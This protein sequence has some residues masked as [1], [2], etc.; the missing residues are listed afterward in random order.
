MQHALPRPPRSPALLVRCRLPRALATLPAQSH[1]QLAA[2]AS[3]PALP[4]SSGPTVSPLSPAAPVQAG[5]IITGTV[6]DINGG[7]VPGAQVTLVEIGK[8]GERVAT[9]D[10]AGVFT[11]DHLP[12]GSY[13]VTITAPGLETFVSSAIVLRPDTRHELPRIALPIATAN[14]SVQVSV[15]QEQLADEQVKAAERQRVFGVF[16]NFY[17]S[18]IWDAAPLKAR[19]KFHLGLRSATDPI[20]FITTG[21]I[22]GSE[23]ANNTFS[24]YGQGTQGYAKRYGAAYADGFIGRIFGSAVFPSVFRQDPRYFYMGPAASTRTRAFHAMRSA[25][26][27]R[28]DN[29]HWQPN[30]SYILGHIVAGAA[31]N[32][33]HPASDR[34][35]ALTF[36][37]ALVGTAGHMGANL[38]RE[39]LLRGLTSHVPDFEQGKHA[40]HTAN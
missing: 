17:T 5:S 11:F 28:G 22:A 13:R 37:N 20:A 24:D 31:S 15:S 39:F 19:Q 6:L 1:A 35:L 3:V 14:T 34:G 18:F 38:V 40:E 4:D 8:P 36:G 21:I 2:R 26:V 9:A 25:V 23:Q 16:P 33:Y 10:S 7:I 30:Y 27:C 12:A 29:G 32:L